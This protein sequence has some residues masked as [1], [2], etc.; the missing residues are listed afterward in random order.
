MPLVGVISQGST[1]RARLSV[2][3]PDLYHVISGIKVNNGETVAPDTEGLIHLW[4]T[5]AAIVADT[6]L[7][8][9]STNLVI[10]KAITQYV[11]LTA[12][13]KSALVALLDD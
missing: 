7:S 12:E 8:L 11:T 9:E 6:E 1:L 4:V 3:A 5:P 2:P 10:N 13:Q